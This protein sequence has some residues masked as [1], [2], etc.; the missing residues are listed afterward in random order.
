MP[1]VQWGYL[2]MQRFR[3]DISPFYPRPLMHTHTHIG[4]H[5]YALLVGSGSMSSLLEPESYL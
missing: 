3:G 1:S 4:T 2:D 5:I